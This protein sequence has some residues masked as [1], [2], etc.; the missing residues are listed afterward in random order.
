MIEF[1]DGYLQLET[2]IYSGGQ[3]ELKAVADRMGACKTNLWKESK[4]FELKAEGLKPERREW[5]K[6][7]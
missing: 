4:G 5:V 3:E 1:R 2:H 6:C 7:R